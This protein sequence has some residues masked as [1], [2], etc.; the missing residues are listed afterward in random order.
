VAKTISLQFDGYWLQSAVSSIP[1]EPGI[2]LVYAGSYNVATDKV[3]IR[4]LVYI[5]ESADVCDRIANHDRWNDWSSHLLTDEILIFGVAPATSPD[6]ERAEAALIHHHKP[7]E[8]V[9]CVDS[10]P[11]DETKVVSS[12]KCKSVGSPITVVTTP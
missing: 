10:F 7:V 12:G 4:Q 6:R 3:S 5:G 8:N 2:Y 9:E 11:H 1:A